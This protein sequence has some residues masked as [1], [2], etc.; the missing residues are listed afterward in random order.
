MK[1][2]A[3]SRLKNGVEAKVMKNKARMQVMKI[4]TVSFT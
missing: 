3:H 1:K 2:A 4:F